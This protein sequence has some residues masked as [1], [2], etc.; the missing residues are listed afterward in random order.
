MK[1]VTKTLTCKEKL[2][3]SQQVKMRQKFFRNFSKLLR[4]KKQHY[5][6]DLSSKD[7]FNEKELF[8]SMVSQFGVSMS[9]IVLKIALFKLINN[10]SKIK[11]S[12]LSL[13]YFKRYLKMIREIC[14]EN[15]SE[16]K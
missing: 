15:A 13:H 2:T 11:N 14:K 12:P 8:V 3:T 5:V 10:Y 16:F 1:K 7:K 4:T 9:T 6:V